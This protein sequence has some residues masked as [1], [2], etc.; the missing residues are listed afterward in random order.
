MHS[1]LLALLVCCSALAHSAD[2]PV[3]LVVDYSALPLLGWSK[4]TGSAPSTSAARP[5]RATSTE[6][7]YDAPLP[8]NMIGS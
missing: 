6:F 5:K 7:L 4:S 8:Y 2:S 1:Q 3:T